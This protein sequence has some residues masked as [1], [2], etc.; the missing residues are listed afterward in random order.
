MLRST[1]STRCSQCRP[2]IASQWHSAL[3]AT[4]PRPMPPAWCSTYRH[5]EW[6]SSVMPLTCPTSRSKTQPKSM[7]TMTAPVAGQCMSVAKY[8]HPTAKSRPSSW[9]P[10][11]SMAAASLCPKTD[12][13]PWWAV[14]VTDLAPVLNRALCIPMS[15]ISATPSNL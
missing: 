11:N 7:W 15:R 6:P 9:T 3:L 1:E 4:A 13:L 12:L 5:N 2:W 14:R 10:L 8:S